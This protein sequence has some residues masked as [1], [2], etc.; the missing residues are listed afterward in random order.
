MAVKEWRG[1]IVFLHRVS[2]GPADRSYGIHVAELAGVPKDVC[3]RAQE[4]LANLERHELNVTGD[5]AMMGGA[6][7]T[8]DRIRQMDLFR[9]PV[10]EIA[11]RLRGLELHELTPLDALNLLADLQKKINGKK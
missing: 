3:E 4:I 2:E 11:D 1:E 5:P 7:S 9:P 10:E 6:D 8:A